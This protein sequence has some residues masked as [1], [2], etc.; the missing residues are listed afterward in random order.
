MSYMRQPKQQITGY[1]AFEQTILSDADKYVLCLFA[2]SEKVITTDTIDV[3]SGYGRRACLT[4]PYWS[5]IRHSLR[6]LA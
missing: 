6:G 1:W 5:G 2:A 4:F 3:F